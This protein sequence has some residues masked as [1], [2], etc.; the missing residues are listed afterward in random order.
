MHDGC[1]VVMCRQSGI[2]IDGLVHSLSPRLRQ[3]LLIA[4]ALSGGYRK[5]ATKHTSTASSGICLIPGLQSVF[6]L[7]ML[8]RS[9]TVTA[10]QLQ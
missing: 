5:P 6:D 3:N 9:A 2:V 10:R 7:E 4:E 1:L 8:F